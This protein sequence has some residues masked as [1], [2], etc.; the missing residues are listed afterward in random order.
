VLAIRCVLK[1]RDRRFGSFKTTNNGRQFSAG[2]GLASGS[3]DFILELIG[4]DLRI[5]IEID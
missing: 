5:S 1:G 2:N 3:N 4:W